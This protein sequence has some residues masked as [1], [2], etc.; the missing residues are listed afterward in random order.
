MKNSINDV[1]IPGENR[2]F[3]PSLSSL[4]EPIETSVEKLDIPSQCPNPACG[5][6]NIRAKGKVPQRREILDCDGGNLKRVILLRPRCECRDCK[7]TFYPNSIASEN[8]GGFSEQAVDML[9]K[10]ILE[11]PETSIYGLSKDIQKRNSFCSPSPIR[12]AITKRLKEIHEE[13]QLIPCSDLFYIPFSYKSRKNCCAVVGSHIDEKG[14]YLLDILQDSSYNELET[15]STKIHFFENDIAMFLVDF[16]DSLIDKIKALFDCPVGIL[17]GLLISWID[18][19]RYQNELPGNNKIKALNALR[20]LVVGDRPEQKYYK[21]LAQWKQDYMESDSILGEDLGCMFNEI[22]RLKRECW[23]GTGHKPWEPEFSM[24]KDIIKKSEY[25]NTSFEFMRFR[26]LYAN[27]A[28]TGT[29]DGDKILRYVQNL[30]KPIEGPIREFGVDI[31]TLYN[32]ILDEEHQIQRL[33][34]EPN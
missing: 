19:F 27:R 26:L 2:L 1:S 3:K 15:F 6:T 34:S 32:E 13:V 8:S 21:D 18:S 16:N 31:K 4:S 28:A 10:N 25:N 23:N 14:F 9:A 7:K 22:I 12:K 30:Y 29:L 5:S 11:H 17:G 33:F 20:K 24:L